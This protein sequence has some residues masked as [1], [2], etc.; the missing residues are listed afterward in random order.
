MTMIKINI[1]LLSGQIMKI[2]A[3]EEE[4][5][6]GL[7]QL[8]KLKEGILVDKINLVRGF[9]ILDNEKTVKESKLEAGEQIN[10]MMLLSTS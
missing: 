1:K 6:S 9:K 10:M 8:V 3:S 5:I 2:N 4:T 7:K